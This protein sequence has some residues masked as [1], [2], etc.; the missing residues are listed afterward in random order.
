MKKLF[1][2]IVAFFKKDHL[3]KYLVQLGLFIIW[4]IIFLV[5]AAE[6]VISNV[7]GTVVGFL[8]TT[9]LL[10]IIKVLF[11]YWEDVL[12]VTD[13]TAYILDIYNGSPDYRK[14]LTLN[15][16]SVTFAYADNLV[17]T[18]YNFHVEDAPEKFFELDEFIMNNYTA[19]FSAHSNSAKVNS[20]T[21]RLDDFRVEGKDCTFYLS[22]STVFNHLVTNRAIDFVLFDGV[23]L[24][25]VYEYGPKITPYNRSKMSNH[26]GINALVFLSDGRL[27]VPR[28]NNKST[29][30]KNQITSSI[31]VKLEF[32]RDKSEVITAEYLMRGNI[33]ESLSSRLK[34]R[35]E[36]LDVSQI[37]IQFLGF[38][39][40]LYEAGKPQLYYC[41][42]LKNI[43]T[44]TYFRLTEDSNIKT[45][46]DTD[47]CIYAAD[48]DSLRFDKNKLHFDVYDGAGKKSKI[49]VVCEMSY[50]AN[51]WHYEALRNSRT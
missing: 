44:A 3:P 15:D 35:P 14:T 18:G 38:G 47:K 7:V 28:R 29:I 45:K 2:Q 34:I 40:N 30:S 43:D 5:W 31:A 46:L 16:T 32:P 23:S 42:Y 13:D 6:E 11:A 10:Y 8:F 1:I 25:S 24:R 22:R 26:V 37:D 9:I 41:V 51:L 12:K 50:Y 19:I 33:I 36:D 48:Y 17:N 20:T 4:L 21:I 49:T 39:Q 27:L